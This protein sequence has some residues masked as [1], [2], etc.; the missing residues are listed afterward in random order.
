MYTPA[1]SAAGSPCRLPARHPLAVS[2]APTTR[3]PAWPGLSVHGVAWLSLV[4]AAAVDLAR[5]GLAERLLARAAGY[6]RAVGLH[7][8]QCLA[9]VVVVVAAERTG[10]RR[11]SALHGRG[12]AARPTDLAGCGG[13]RPP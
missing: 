5:A 13:G 7:V 3:A 12:L 6:V 8:D 10:R 11:H 9:L 2:V 4:R 1:A